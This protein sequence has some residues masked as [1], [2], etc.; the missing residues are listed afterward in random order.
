M[1]E[2]KWPD[3]ITNEQVLERIGEKRTLVNNIPRISQLDWSYSDHGIEGNMT[4]VKG[5]AR[6]RIQLLDDLRNRRI[7]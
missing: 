6:R 2:I 7:Y 4:E 5:V 3:K 1:E